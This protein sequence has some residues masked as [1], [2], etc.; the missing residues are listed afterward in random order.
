MARLDIRVFGDP[1]LDRQGERIDE[2]DDRI[3]TLVQDM[4]E[5]MKAAPGIGL[6]APQVGESLQLCLID[7]SA[8]EDPDRLLVMI[9]PEIIEMEGQQREE[10]GCLSFP[11]IFGFVER[12]S[13]VKVR[14]QDMEGETKEIEGEELL[15]RALCHEI[16]HLNGE[17]FIFKMSPLKKKMALKSI[18]K[19]EKEGQWGSY[20]PE[21]NEPSMG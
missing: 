8:G 1:V 6:A 20:R 19:L 17:L 18:R 21:G 15:A 3:R 5:T 14:Y 7:L 12:P 11:G 13:R 16:D 9:N 4:Y 10:E 2:I